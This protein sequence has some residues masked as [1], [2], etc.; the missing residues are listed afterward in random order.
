MW[1]GLIVA[2]L[3]P[4]VVPVLEAQTF[5]AGV[6]LVRL[7]VVVASGN[8]TLVEGLRA[9]DF[10]VLEEG[11]PQSIATFAVAGLDASLP[12]HLGLMLDKSPSMEPDRAAAASAVIRFV[13]LVDHAQDVTFVEFDSRVRMG[14]YTPGNYLR[15]FQRIREPSEGTETALYD[16]MG[17]Y[18]DAAA[19]RPGQHVLVVYTDGADSASRLN[20]GDIRDRL[21]LGEVVL[22][23]VGFLEQQRADRRL[24]QQAILTQL[25]RETGGDAF[26]QATGQRL[27]S[28][29]ERIQLEIA[30]RYLLGYVPTSGTRK[31]EFRHVEVRLTDPARRG[32]KVR[33]RSGYVALPAP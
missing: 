32:L 16:A 11:R 3:L 21:R 6:S 9:E 15:L 4:A 29:Y 25:A 28:F 2:G 20:I 33:T 22:Y 31:E 23:V 7:P 27:T 26:F 8:G 10:Q 13:E 12:L 1:R 30:G 5:R 17:H 18:R 24:Q 14:R 19:G